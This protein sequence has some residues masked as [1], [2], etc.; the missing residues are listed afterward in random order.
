MKDEIRKVVLR[1]QESPELPGDHHQRIAGT[2]A[3]MDRVLPGTQFFDE[4]ERQLSPGRGYL[5]ERTRTLDVQDLDV[6]ELSLIPV[7]DSLGQQFVSGRSQHQKTAPHPFLDYRVDSFAGD[8][9]PPK[10]IPGPGG[11]RGCTRF[12]VGQEARAYSKNN[13]VIHIK[14]TY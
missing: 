3:D 7:G 2:Q 4:R 1:L 8:I 5:F 13:T 14:S 11:Y 12:P 6:A 9:I 10:L